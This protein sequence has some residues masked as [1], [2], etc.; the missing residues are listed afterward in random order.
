LIAPSG[1]DPRLMNLR[2][3]LLASIPGCA[4]WLGARL[5]RTCITRMKGHRQ[6]LEPDMMEQ[7]GL[8]YERS[9]HWAETNPWFPAAVISQI[10]HLPSHEAL[11]AQLATIAALTIPIH[12]LRFGNEQDSTDRGLVP[13]LN[14][15]SDVSIGFLSKGSHMGLLE[16][17][18]AVSSWVRKTL[19]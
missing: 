7:S 16:H 13:F 5:K 6:L 1:F 17:S 19:C 3:R 18:S 2:V 14:A 12:A 10:R 15:L 11:K 9:I 4:R 8:I